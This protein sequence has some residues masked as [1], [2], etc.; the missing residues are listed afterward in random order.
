MAKVALVFVVNFF[1]NYKDERTARATQPN[2]RTA[3]FIKVYR[4]F[5]LDVI[6][7][8]LISPYK[9]IQKNINKLGTRTWLPWPLSFESH[10]NE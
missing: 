2:Q 9:R 1:V 3:V 5:A 4:V 8:I 10:E 7:A 6:A